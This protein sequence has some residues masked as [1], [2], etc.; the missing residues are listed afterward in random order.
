MDGTGAEERK[1]ERKRIYRKKKRAQ[2]AGRV[3]RLK[4]TVNKTV[5]CQKLRRQSLAFKTAVDRANLT[6]KTLKK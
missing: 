5:E 2:R 1:S 3:E 4:E 6:T